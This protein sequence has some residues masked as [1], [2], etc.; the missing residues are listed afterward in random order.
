[1]P[2][3][4]AAP[5]A[6]IMRVEATGDATVAPGPA[7]NTGRPAGSRATLDICGAAAAGACRDSNPAAGGKA[8]FEKSAREAIDRRT[9]VSDRGPGPIRSIE[10]TRDDPSSSRMTRWCSREIEAA[11]AGCPRP[12]R[13]S[14]QKRAGCTVGGWHARGTMGVWLPWKPESASRFEELAPGRA[15]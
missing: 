8:D 12:A 13:V 10:S 11:Y 6:L 1:M 4:A 3:G 14:F 7:R 15:R 9:P 2:L 5:N